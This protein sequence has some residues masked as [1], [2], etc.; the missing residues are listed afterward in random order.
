LGLSSGDDFYFSYGPENVKYL[1]R[2]TPDN[3]IIP[4]G[5]TAED[6]SKEKINAAKKL[7]ETQVQDYMAQQSEFI[8]APHPWFN[9]QWLFNLTH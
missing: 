3:K 6:I 7:F 5:G 1:L 8:G 4:S 9:L 2:L